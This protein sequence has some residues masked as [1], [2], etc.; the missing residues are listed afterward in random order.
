M[1]YDFILRIIFKSGTIYD[2]TVEVPDNT[3][4]QRDKMIEGAR[5]ML[6]SREQIIIEN[7]S[8]ESIINPE[9]VSSII[10]LLEEGTFANS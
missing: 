10:I 9:D 6:D 5:A 1:K 7:K 3:Q 2:Y 4:E 8:N